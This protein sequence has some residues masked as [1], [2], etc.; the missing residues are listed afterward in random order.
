M[1]RERTAVLWEVSRILTGPS[2]LRREQAEPACKRH[3][4]DA[5][6]LVYRLAFH[7]HEHQHPRLILSRQSQ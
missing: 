5:L 7:Y 1:A 6:R 3:T 4:A 2:N